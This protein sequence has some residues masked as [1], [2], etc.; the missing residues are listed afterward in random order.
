MIMENYEKDY[1]SLDEIMQVVCTTFGIEKELL[2]SKSRAKPLPEI[3]YI[4]FYLAKYNAKV[5]EK[6]VNLQIIA[7]YCNRKTHVSVLHGIRN[8]KTWY[9]TDKKF[10]E[11]ADAVKLIRAEIKLFN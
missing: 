6:K 4:F 10:R 11:K 8:Y 2:I 7:D 5:K 1:F 3:R 9:I